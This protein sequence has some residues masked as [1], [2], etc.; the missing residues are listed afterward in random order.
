M[1]STL[2]GKGTARKT[3]AEPPRP[4]AMAGVE[5]S[6]T[7]PTDPFA[8]SENVA[9]GR[10]KEHDFLLTRAAGPVLVSP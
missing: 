3:L 2:S 1:Q 8:P 5:H 6:F 7:G 9:V 4:R 10:A